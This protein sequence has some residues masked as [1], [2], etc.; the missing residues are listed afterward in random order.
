MSKDPTPARLAKLMRQWRAERGLSTSDAGATLNLSA[1]TV[2]GIEQERGFP[3]A[4]RVLEIALLAL[5][6]KT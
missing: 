3:S 2:E 1:R 4:P 5:I 6:T